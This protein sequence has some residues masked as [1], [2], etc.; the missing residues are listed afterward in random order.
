MVVVV[1]GYEAHVN[2][3]MRS[4]EGFQRRFPG[5]VVFPPFSAREAEQL[6]IH[7]LSLKRVALDA[8]S[9]AFL[10]R[11]LEQLIAVPGWS[12][13]GDVETLDR[14]IR[15]A[16]TMRLHR[17]PADTQ[18]DVIS[19]D[20]QQG[21]A[22][23]M[24]ARV[25]AEVEHN[26]HAAVSGLPQPALWASAAST[27]AAA[28]AAAATAPARLR[29][30]DDASPGAGDSAAAGP[31]D[32]VAAF[33]L[34]PV[35]AS[36][37]AAERAEVED[38]FAAEQARLQ[39]E[40]EERL[41]LEAEAAEA[42]R[43]KEEARLEAER[44]T[45]LLQEALDEAERQRLDELRRAALEAAHLKQ[46][47]LDRIAAAQRAAAEQRQREAAIQRRLQS[48]GRC[49]AGYAWLPVSGGYRCAGGSHFVSNE[50]IGV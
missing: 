47:E 16:R 41:R 6:L 28:A 45:R 25:P 14:L 7:K 13:A 20:L 44:I 18:R 24:A 11:M 8:T 10:P 38:A 42:L 40:E 4:N 2:R 48:I 27:F 33:A 1:A 23:L 37:S 50:H 22:D 29:E 43:L 12:S 5:K 9:A 21:C 39:R 35:D 36:A 26:E 30:S 17:N 3:L 19:S 15:K 34:P 49:M 46:L 31:V 32:A